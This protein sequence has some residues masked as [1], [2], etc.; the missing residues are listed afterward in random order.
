MP[1]TTASQC[2]LALYAGAGIKVWELPETWVWAMTCP[3]A[4]RDVGQYW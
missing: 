4:E 2:R 1:C 3:G